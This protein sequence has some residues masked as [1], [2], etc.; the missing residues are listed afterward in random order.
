M[1]KPLTQVQ[2][3]RLNTLVNR[4]IQQAENDADMADASMRGRQLASQEEGFA[5]LKLTDRELEE[6]GWTREDLIIATHS[7]APRGQVPVY[8]HAAHERH[9]LR[10][11]ARENAGAQDT[12]KAKGYVL[13]A[14]AGRQEGG[15]ARLAPADEDE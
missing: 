3:A 7:V 15:T 8:L 2:T 9:G 12:P 1:S 11:R 13:P 6:K 14:P 10:I 4:L 5:L